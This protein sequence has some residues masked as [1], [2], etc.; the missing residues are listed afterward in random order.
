MYFLFVD[1]EKLIK[2]EMFVK[3]VCP[4]PLSLNVIVTLTYD[5]EIPNS[6]GAIY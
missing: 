5:L 1:K 3:H 4:P 2:Q 6:I